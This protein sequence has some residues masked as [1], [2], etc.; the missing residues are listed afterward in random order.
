[1]VADVQA[2]SQ[3]GLTPLSILTNLSVQ[4]TAGVTD[5]HEISTDIIIAQYQALQADIDFTVVKIGLLSSEKQIHTLANLS[6]GKTIVLDPI[7][8]PS[9]GNAFLNS[10]LI[11]TLKETL[12]PQVSIL[13]P[14]M[15]E[16]QALS[17]K[18]KTQQAVEALKCPWILLTTTDTSEVNIEHCLYHHQQLI[19]KFNYPKLPNHY[20]GS[21]CT[22]SS[23]LAALIAKGVATDIACK[24]ALDYTYQTLLNA[25]QVGKMQLHPQR[26]LSL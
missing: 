4:N 21:G 14:N 18:E 8:K 12:L 20:H 3:F 16:L 13:T 15:A 23:A 1:M 11:Q 17:G 24:Q 7:V 19:C 9:Y 10:T 2:I 5:L 6:Q 25:V 22:L 26:I